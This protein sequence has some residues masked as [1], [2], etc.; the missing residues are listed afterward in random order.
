LKKI[1]VGI[2][3][4]G[5][6][7]RSLF[8]ILLQHPEIEVVAIN[9]LADARTLSHLVKYDSIHGVLPENVGYKEEGITVKDKLYPLTQIAKIEELNWQKYQVDF[10]IES[11]GK[12]KNT[13]ELQCHLE[14]GAKKSNFISSSG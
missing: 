11:T 13:S 8:R 9:D 4:F 3:G 2:N 7:G 6:I 1:K 10:V 14:N 5:R 12:F